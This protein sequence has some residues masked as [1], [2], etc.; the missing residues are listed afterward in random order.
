MIKSISY[1]TSE[2]E[3][4][5][6]SCMCGKFYL[7][8]ESSKRRESKAFSAKDF[9]KY[10]CERDPYITLKK[11]GYKLRVYRGG[12]PSDE[13]IETISIIESH[14]AKFKN[15]YKVDYHSYFDHEIWFH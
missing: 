15:T 8:K 1:L 12:D 10:V 3:R 4:K 11:D 14:D 13:V 2:G 5:H 7:V 9:V 6:V